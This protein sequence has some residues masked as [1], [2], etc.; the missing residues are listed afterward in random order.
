MKISL[1][2]VFITIILISGGL[3]FTGCDQHS[4]HTDTEQFN[5]ET[6]QSDHIDKDSDHIDKHKAV[7]KKTEQ[8]IKKPEQ[9]K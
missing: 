1:C 4:D 3:I 6:G 7:L 5:Q 2:L 9:T 8:T